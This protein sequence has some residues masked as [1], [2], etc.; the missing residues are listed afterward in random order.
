MARIHVS[1]AIPAS[2]ERVWE[3]VRDFNELPKWFPGLTDCHIE[4][5]AAANQPGCIRNFGLQGGV[6]IR[7]QLLALSDKDYSWSYKMVESPLPVTNYVAA[8]RFSAGDGKGTLAE[9]TSQFDVSPEQEKE[10]VALLT[11]TYQAAF[12]MLKEHFGKL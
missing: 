9:I 6:R 1:S 5:G 3:Y 4:P 11:T 12:E 10:T 8:V 2:V 7:E